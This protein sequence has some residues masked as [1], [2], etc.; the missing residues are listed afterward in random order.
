MFLITLEAFN[1]LLDAVNKLNIVPLDMVHS[2]PSCLSQIRNLIDYMIDSQ[3][4]LGSEF[5]TLYKNVTR[6]L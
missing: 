4:S 6:Y 1:Q 3:N 2:V 5:L